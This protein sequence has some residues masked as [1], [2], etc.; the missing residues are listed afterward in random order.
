[1]ARARW[2]RVASHVWWLADWLAAG[3]GP[4]LAWLIST[5]FSRLDWAAGTLACIPRAKE[6]HMA[7]GSGKGWRNRLHLLKE[8]LT[9]FCKRVCS[10]ELATTPGGWEGGSGRGR[11]TWRRDLRGSGAFF[12]LMPGLNQIRSRWHGG[13][14]GGSGTSQNAGTRLAMS[15]SDLLRWGPQ[16]V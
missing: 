3:W 12:T 15:A 13:H 16:R 10:Q 7:E 4:Q 11:V 2:C 14:L 9:S 8:E 6:C 5:P 1:M